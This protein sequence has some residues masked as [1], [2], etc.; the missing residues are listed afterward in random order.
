LAELL[1]ALQVP[2]QMTIPR[3]FYWAWN[4]KQFE[5]NEG[6][7]ILLV[8][9]PVIFLDYKPLINLPLRLYGLP[10][11]HWILNSYETDRLHQYT[12]D[13]IERLSLL[14]KQMNAY[15]YVFIPARHPQVARL[16]QLIDPQ[17]HYMISPIIVDP[18][19]KFS[20]QEFIAAIQEYDPQPGQLVEIRYLANLMDPQLRRWLREMKLKIFYNQI[21]RT[22]R[23]QFE[24][25]YKHNLTRLYDDIFSQGDDLWIQTDTPDKLRDYLI[26]KNHR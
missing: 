5:V 12:R 1:G 14:L 3:H 4:S 25:P 9:T 15:P 7:V 19:H 18:Q 21:D 2:N 8:N 22:D 16:I 17:I 11:W 6:Q 24:G 26:R 23:S 13:A 20:A 10:D